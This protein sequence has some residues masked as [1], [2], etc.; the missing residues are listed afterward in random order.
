MDKELTVKYMTL[1]EVKN[2]SAKSTDTTNQYKPMAEQLKELKE[3]LDLG[4]LTENEFNEQK[5]RILNG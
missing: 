3:L 4:I 5:R 2:T 1:Y